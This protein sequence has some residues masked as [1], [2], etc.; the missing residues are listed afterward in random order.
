MAL[1][2][3]L[4]TSTISQSPPLGIHIELVCSNIYHE[5][6]YIYTLSFK[7]RFTTKVV[8]ALQHGHHGA[9]S[10]AHSHGIQQSIVQKLTSF[11]GI[12][13]DRFTTMLLTKARHQFVT[14][15]AQEKRISRQK[16][17]RHSCTWHTARHGRCILSL[18][19]IDQ[20][21]T[22]RQGSQRLH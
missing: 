11:Y 16:Q 12:L 18:F 7:A 14:V 22:Q 17:Q 10:D 15:Q 5:C 9:H 3:Q 6:V 13:I 19:T 4:A 2:C 21:L 20:R 8:R 1:C